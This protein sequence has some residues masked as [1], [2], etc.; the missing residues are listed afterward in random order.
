[1]HDQYQWTGVAETM[2]ILN[3]FAGIGG[4]RTLWGDDHYITAIEQNEKIAA[5]YERRFPNDHVFVTDA[6]DFLEDTYDQYDF[7]WASP[8]CPSHSQM[9]KIQQKKI[10]PDLRLYSLIIFLQTWF[11][12]KWVVENVVPYYKPL[13]KPMVELERHYIW[14]NFLIPSKEFKFRTRE[15]CKSMTKEELSE[16]HQIPLEIIP[17]TQY[18]KGHDNMRQI[19]RNCVHYEIGKYILDQV[20]NPLNQQ[21]LNLFF[22]LI[23]EG[24]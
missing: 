5:I 22:K 11:K 24:L 1:M 21:S 9:Q 13:I 15:Y 23:T 4:N 19:L 12:G 18:F 3:L 10:L 6:Y 7:I 16:F 2:K 14:S 20:K 8:P 17:Y